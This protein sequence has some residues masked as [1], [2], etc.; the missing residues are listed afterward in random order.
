MADE[1]PAHE[2]RARDDPTEAPLQRRL[3]EMRSVLSG[4]QLTLDVGEAAAARVTRSEI[5]DQIDDYLLPRLAAIDAPLLAVIGGSTGSG[6]STLTNTLVG[7][8]ISPAGVLRPTTRAPV[9]VCN[10]ADVDWFLSGGVLPDLARVTGSGRADQAVVT[11]AALV[12]RSIEA[13]P[14]GLAFL[15]SPDIDSIETANHELAA[16][17]LGAADLWLFVTTAA[18]Y[19]DAVPWE[20]LGRA[21]DRAVALGLVINRIPPGAEAEV[22][23]HLGEMLASHGLADAE[24]FSIAE[25]PVSD[26]RLLEGIEPVRTWL[27]GLAADAEE[28]QALIRKTIAGAVA[29]LPARAALVVAALDTQAASAQALS[30]LA[31]HRYETALENIDRE[32]RSGNLLRGEVLDTWQEHVGT[33]EFMQKLQKGI[34][35]LRDRVKSVFTGTDANPELEVRDELQSSLL[36][37]VRQ[38]ADF[39]A[40]DVVEGWEALPGGSQLLD[41]GPRDL[42]R[43]SST[44]TARF[45]EEV[46]SW[47]DGVLAL[48]RNQAGNK[49]ALARGLSLGINGVGVG[50]MVA[51]FSHTGGVTGGEA[52]VA[53][54]TAAVSQAMLSAVFGE[55]AVRDLANSARD[56]LRLRLAQLLFE[57][58]QRFDRLV[59]DVPGDDAA[60]RLRATITALGKVGH[61]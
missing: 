43:T 36:A 10:P 8:A 58:R 45:D 27:Y 3:D 44:L 51:V 47:Q 32:L 24:V 46:R 35:R 20:Y 16:Q 2:N 6:K 55:Q 42:S 61:R 26:D 1:H 4:A 25:G 50:L 29:S 14:A 59:A 28:R 37:L 21:A 40:L 15:D 39:A 22:E 18:R 38:A 53:A 30:A 60:E 12:I 19:A 17:L 54:G 33:G 11:G 34:G 23:T 31:E 41:A 52:G 48:V 56:D 57:E 49:L 9:L 5:L 7:E 13:V